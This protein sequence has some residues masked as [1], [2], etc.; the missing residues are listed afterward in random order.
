L[1]KREVIIRDTT[2]AQTLHDE[3]SALGS[4]MIEDVLE[5]IIAGRSLDPQ[6]QNDELSNYAPMLKKEEGL[7]DWTQ[8]ASLID[9]KIRAFTPWPGCYTL[10]KEGT[11]IKVIAGNL[12]P[13]KSSESAGTL[14][15]KDGDVACGQGVYRVTLVQ[16]EN[17]RPMDIQSAINGKK[18][19]I[20]QRW[21][22]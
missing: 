18:L 3:L 4:A 16:P 6:I 17:S 5:D 12:R 15:S 10:D 21:G 19:A 7:I 2:T 14:L 1:S 20:G 9:L 13:E 8:S 11:R 22:A